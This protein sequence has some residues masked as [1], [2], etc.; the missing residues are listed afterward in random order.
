MPVGYELQAKWD[1]W[2]K[3][4]AMASEMESAT[5]FIVGAVRS[6]RTGSIMAVLANQTRR[7]LGLPDAVTFDVNAAIRIGVGAIAYLI[8]EDRE[9][10]RS[11]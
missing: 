7:A 11:T 10:S 4:G 5:L 6:V 2:V 1:A 8:R 3:C 9:E